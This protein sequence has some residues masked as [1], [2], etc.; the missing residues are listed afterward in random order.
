MRSPCGVYLFVMTKSSE[1]IKA[2]D[3][4]KMSQSDIYEK[5]SVDESLGFASYVFPQVDYF[6][7]G[8]TFYGPKITKF[9]QFI[10][11]IFKELGIA[12]VEF[13]MSALTSS[14]TVTEVLQMPFVARTTFEIGK[15]NNLFQNLKEYFGDEIETDTEAVEIIIKPKRR[16]DMN[17]SFQ[18]IASTIENADLK[19]FIVKAKNE[20]GEA[21]TDFYIVGSGAISDLISVSQNEGSI[22]ATMRRKAIANDLL[23]EKLRE[24]IDEENINSNT[25]NVNTVA[26][27]EHDS[28]WSD[29]FNPEGS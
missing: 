12:G 4:N 1:I 5:L 19:K 2:I 6:G 24:F 8:S 21:A 3:E 16:K 28:A 27:F 13:K 25:Q 26:I 10:N 17:N 18:A 29:F 7:M 23:S 11:R 9:S 14:A 20:L 22:A 15:N